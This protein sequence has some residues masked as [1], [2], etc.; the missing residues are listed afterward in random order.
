[1]ESASHIQVL[2]SV[3][4]VSFLIQIPAKYTWIHSQRWPRYWVL[5]TTNVGEQ[6][7][8]PGTWLHANLDLASV[9]IQGNQPAGGRSFSVFSTPSFPV[10]LSNKK[11]LFKNV[12]LKPSRFKL[13]NGEMTSSPAS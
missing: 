3:S 12:K 13:M 5:A 11:V 1:M 7:E 8:T 6:D 9:A 4:S 10:L 2:G